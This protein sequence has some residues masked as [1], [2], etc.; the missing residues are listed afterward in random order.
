MNRAGNADSEY[1][2]FVIAVTD[3]SVD[4]LGLDKNHHKLCKLKL[5]AGLIM[6][7]FQS[8]WRKKGPNNSR[9]W[10]ISISD[11][12]KCSSAN[13]VFKTLCQ[14][15]LCDIVTGSG[16]PEEDNGEVFKV[17]PDLHILH[18]KIFKQPE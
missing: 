12:S 8:P 4:S 16:E 5:F 11:V 13:A 6:H 15:D 3:I 9:F 1:I 10:S 7:S 17:A 18:P 2:W 14:L